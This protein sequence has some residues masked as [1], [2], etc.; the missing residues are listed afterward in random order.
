LIVFRIASAAGEQYV[1]YANHY[2]LGAK[3]KILT[4]QN[5]INTLR[6][7]CDSV[8]FR[9]WIAS[10]YIGSLN[11]VEKILGGKWLKESKV[12][13]RLI[14]DVEELSKLSR[15]TISTF[16]NRGMVKSLRG[17]H[18]KIYII[19]DD[20]LLT[21]A[22]LTATAFSKRHEVGCLLKKSGAKNTISLYESWWKGEAERMPFRWW[23]G[24]KD[25]ADGNDSSE[26]KEGKRL[27]KL[28]NLPKS[29][30]RRKKIESSKGF[31]DYISFCA[32]YSDFRSMYAEIQR[33]RK[34]IPLNLEVDGFL[35]YLFH[36][37]DQPSQKYGK[38]KGRTI[39]PPRSLNKKRKIK[40]IEKYSRSFKKW[41]EEGNDISWRLKTSEFI[42]SKLTR[43]DIRSITR[44]DITDIANKLNCM[45]SLPLNK[46]RFINSEN[47][48]LKTIRNAW[49]ILLHGDEDLQVRMTKCRDMLNWFGNSSVQE[50]L[51]FYFPHKYPIRNSNVNAGLRF[52]GY[53]VSLD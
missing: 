51:G 20:V 24:L 42:R 6:T 5:L 47:N 31:L 35:D 37:D 12:S 30:G 44:R 40:E 36:H 13:I 2:I 48:N 10:P 26:D 16:E 38:L 23:N 8:D 49:Y 17:L 9:L 45:N 1:G 46:A 14:T 15:E 18:A 43:R 29:S 34:D 4:G 50:L 41:V 3:M 33:I 7:L 53:A 11:S 39:I 25:R 52:F 19:D 28:W 27:P 22:N 32:R 21:S